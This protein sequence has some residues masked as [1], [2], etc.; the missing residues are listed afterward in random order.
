M[1]ISGLGSGGMQRNK[2]IAQPARTFMPGQMAAHQNLGKCVEP[3]AS[4]SLD[5]I[6]KRGR[7]GG[8][9]QICGEEET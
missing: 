9:C 2:A 1:V 3:T 8:Q 4:D 6:Q 7:L 5:I